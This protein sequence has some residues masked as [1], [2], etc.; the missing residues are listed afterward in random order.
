M[1]LNPGVPVL[2]R[3]H[4]PGADRRRDACHIAEGA[5][6][7]Y[8]GVPPARARAAPARAPH[9]APEPPRAP[10]GEPAPRLPPPPSAPNATNLRGR[11]IPT[12]GG[13][14]VSAAA[15]VT[16]VSDVANFPNVTNVSD[17]TTAVNVANQ[18]VVRTCVSA[19]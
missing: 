6:P 18:T 5:L 8:V 11:P 3:R 13:T 10:T 1:L 16:D 4:E 14:G 9:R 17:V 2:R 12:A 15:N 19:Y 7:R